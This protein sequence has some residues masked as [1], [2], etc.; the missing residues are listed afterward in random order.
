MAF[1]VLVVDDS[2]VMRTMIIRTL[3]LSGVELGEIYQAASGMEGLERLGNNW[4]DIALVDINMPV[5][6]GEEMIDQVRQNPEMAELPILVVST[7]GSDTRIERLR[8]KGA[9]F[10]HKP[11]SPEALRETILHITGVEDEHEYGNGS[12]SGSSFDF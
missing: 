8:Q 3:R 10:L 4:V 6:N 7:E 1:N 11:F 12:I 2:A 9:G 5:M